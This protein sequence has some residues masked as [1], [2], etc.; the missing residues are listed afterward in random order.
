MPSVARKL[1][2]LDRNLTLWIFA[3]VGLGVALGRLPRTSRPVA[4]TADQ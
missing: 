3:A 4:A 1:S 2:F